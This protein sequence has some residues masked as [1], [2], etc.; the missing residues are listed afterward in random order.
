MTNHENCK[1]KILQKV[2]I[3]NSINNIWEEAKKEWYLVTIFDDE[4]ASCICTQDIRENCVIKNKYNN[5]SLIVG[6]V[7][8]NRFGESELKVKPAVRI[9][10]KKLQNRPDKMKASKALLNLAFKLQ[11]ISLFEFDWYQ[12]Y[13]FK[14]A[15]TTLKNNWIL[16]ERIRLNWLII[17]GFS[18]FRPKCF[19]KEYAK[20]RQNRTTK[21]YFYSCAKWKFENSEGCS[22]TQNCGLTSLIQKN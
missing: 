16:I 8:I 2:I 3:E 18:R 12:K 17:Y 21:N 13:G 5:K 11:V 1:F 4:F 9:S 19:C 20:P 6:N 10:L 7:C 22:F 14:N 15:S